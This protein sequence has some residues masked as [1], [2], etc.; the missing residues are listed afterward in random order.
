MTV[1]A[2][3]RDNSLSHMYA[4]DRMG[5]QVLAHVSCQLACKRKVN[6]SHIVG[7]GMKGSLTSGKGKA[8]GCH[9][10]QRMSHSPRCTYLNK[11]AFGVGSC[12]TMHGIKGESEVWLVQQS[13]QGIKVKDGAQQLQ[14]ILH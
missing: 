5:C 9:W 4:V 13:F 1:K 2:S 11:D 3:G 6:V 12:H 10:A 8:C 7:Q 14:V